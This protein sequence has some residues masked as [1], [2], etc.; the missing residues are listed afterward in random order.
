VR[1]KLIVEKMGLQTNYPGSVIPKVDA[2][3][4]DLSA[5]RPFTRLVVHL[6][7]LKAQLREFP[8]LKERETVLPLLFA[9]IL[10]QIEDDEVTGIWWRL[11]HLSREEDDKA[12]SPPGDKKSSVA[13]RGRKDDEDEDDTDNDAAPSG[14]PLLSQTEVT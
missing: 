13:K 12:K 14:T 2:S 6:S 11:E 1:A 4:H 5:S 8:Q 7:K 3:I 10:D 9:R